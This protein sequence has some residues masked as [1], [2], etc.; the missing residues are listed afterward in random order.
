LAAIFPRILF[1]AFTGAYAG[2]YAKTRKK[3]VSKKKDFSRS[4]GD[5]SG[6]VILWNY[7]ISWGIFPQRCQN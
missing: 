4:F 6:P 5:Y 7:R 2:R 3:K 1:L